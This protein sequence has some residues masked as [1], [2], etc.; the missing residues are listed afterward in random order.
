M[1]CK[2]CSEELH[3]DDGIYDCPRCDA[4]YRWVPGL[5]LLSTVV[6]GDPEMID[7]AFVDECDSDDFVPSRYRAEKKY[8]NKL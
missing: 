3:L 5:N 7:L 4:V 8:A 2:N 1:I 6:E